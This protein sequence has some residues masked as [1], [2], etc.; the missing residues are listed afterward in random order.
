MLNI[1]LK[2]L[3]CCTSTEEVQSL[4]C[5]AVKSLSYD[6]FE[7]WLDHAAILC[8]LILNPEATE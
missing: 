4:A 2:R 5:I 1:F 6:E 3:S 7:T 8:A